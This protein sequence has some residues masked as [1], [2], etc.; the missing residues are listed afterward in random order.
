MSNTD[1]DSG[2]GRGRRGAVVAVAVAMTV[3]LVAGLVGFLA[4][5]LG[6]PPDV[7]SVLDQRASVV[8]MFVGAAGLVVAVAALVSQS[9]SGRVDAG[10][11][12]VPEAGGAAPAPVTQ[13]QLNLPSAGGIVNAV[14]G[15]TLNIHNPA[16]PATPP[17]GDGREPSS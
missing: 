2:R 4:D 12:H 9:R 3:L 17:P 10:P 6:L 5:P 13:T 16:A 8:S 14:Q 15:G 7:L 1:P 11:P